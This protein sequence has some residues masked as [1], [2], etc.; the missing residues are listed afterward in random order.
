M[1]PRVAKATRKAPADRRGPFAMPT[2]TSIRPDADAR[3]RGTSREC[4]TSQASGLVPTPN[5]AVTQ[6]SDAAGTPPPATP[7]PMVVSPMPKL[8]WGVLVRHALG[9]FAAHGASHLFLLATNIP[10]EREGGTPSPLAARKARRNQVSSGG[11]VTY[12]MAQE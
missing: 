3:P 12:A 1:R 5:R 9:P 11:L 10:G 4:M 8:A 6:V 2:S 7:D